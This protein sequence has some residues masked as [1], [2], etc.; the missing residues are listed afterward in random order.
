M[1][2]YNPTGAC[3]APACGK[4]TGRAHA[5]YCD[6]CR[7]PL[8]VKPLKYAWSPERDQVLRNRYD[9]RVR[10]RAAEIAVTLGVPVHTVKQRAAQLGL[11]HPCDDRRDWTAEEVAFLEEHAGARHVSW[12]ARR[13]KRTTSS[14]VQKLKRLK[15]SRFVRVG[16]NMSGLEL[17]FG[18]EHRVI[19]RWIREGRLR[20]RRIPGPGPHHQW[21]FKDTAIL[22]FVRENPTAFELRR[23]DQTWFLDLLFSRGVVA[24][25]MTAAYKREA[26]Q[27]CARS[28]GGV[29]DDVPAARHRGVL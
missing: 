26:E 17:C 6:A 27:R 11:T 13:L 19:E 8:R 15:V 3:Q 7:W 9:G 10:G 20:G 24:R 2:C 25:A 18:V 28:D 29:A 12:L 5:R 23:V 22:R 16:Y 4:P 21:T 14:I 1:G